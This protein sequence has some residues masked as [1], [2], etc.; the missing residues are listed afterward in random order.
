AGL[1]AARGAR[2]LKAFLKGKTNARFSRVTILAT[3]AYLE[4]ESSCGK[5]LDTANNNEET[6]ENR[7]AA[8]QDV[9]DLECGSYGLAG[10]GNRFELYKLYARA[11]ADTLSGKYDDES[12]V[13]ADY[14]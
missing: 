2:A 14:T 1:L 12:L 8:Q 10:A 11:F 13:E 9:T 4:W 6:A 5:A 3:V 7:A